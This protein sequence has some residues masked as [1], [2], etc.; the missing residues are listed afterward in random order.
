MTRGHCDTFFD[1]ILKH[2]SELND[3]D[4]ASLIKSMAEIKAFTDVQFKQVL[5]E[6]IMKNL[7]SF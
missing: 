7:D 2:D 4:R 5:E 1:Y 6:M 3:F